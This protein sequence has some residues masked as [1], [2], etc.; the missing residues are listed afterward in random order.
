MDCPNCNTEARVEGIEKD[1]SGGT[2]L[3]YICVNA[4]CK[5]YRKEV[6]SKTVEEAHS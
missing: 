6:G 5:N 2:I 3:H 4:R 1:E